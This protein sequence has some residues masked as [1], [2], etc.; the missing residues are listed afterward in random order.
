MKNPWTQKPFLNVETVRVWTGRTG[1]E[2]VRE[3]ECLKYAHE[4]GCPWDEETCYYAARGGHLEILKYAHEKGC[5]WDER[6]AAY[7]WDKMTS[8]YDASGGHLVIL[9]YLR[10]KGLCP[11]FDAALDAH[12]EDENEILESGYV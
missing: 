7:I 4:K 9:K 12:I 5:P 10:E 8:F 2:K 6:Q 1:K 3:L 11:A